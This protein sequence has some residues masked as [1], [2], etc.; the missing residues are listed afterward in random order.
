MKSSRHSDVLASEMCG[1]RIRENYRYP[2]NIYLQIHIRAS[3]ICRRC[4]AF[5][6][7]VSLK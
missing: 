1:Y 4:C 3:L 6:N 5:L 7:V 2:R